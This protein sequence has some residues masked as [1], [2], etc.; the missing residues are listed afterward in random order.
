M[1]ASVDGMV[2]GLMAKVPFANQPVL[3]THLGQSV[4]HCAYLC[5]HSKLFISL[6]YIEFP[7][8][9]LLIQAGN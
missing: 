7:A 3:V 5:A 8:V 6:R 4:G 2:L 1:E 9:P